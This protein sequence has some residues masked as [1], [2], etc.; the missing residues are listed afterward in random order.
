MRPSA[1]AI[2][3][4]IAVTVLASDHEVTVLVVPR[5]LIAFDEDR[6]ATGDEEAGG[7]VA[8]EVIVKGECLALI[9]V[10]NCRFRGRARQ[11]R[12]RR[13]AAHQATLIDLVEMALASDEEG[14]TLTRPA[15]TDRVAIA[16]AVVLGVRTTLGEPRTAAAD[17]SPED[18][19]P[20]M[21]SREPVGGGDAQPARTAVSTH[22]AASD[23]TTM[24]SSPR[25]CECSTRST[26][27][28]A[29]DAAARRS[30]SLSR[31]RCFI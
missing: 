8:R 23:S 10:A 5:V 13:G 26:G 30:K 14:Y 28:V 24:P 31:Q 16:R 20:A 1:I 4:S 22:A 18:D 27:I 17:G 11:R 25:R 7:R 21:A 15:G 19:P 29:S 3:T 2:P 6:V 9:L 12:R